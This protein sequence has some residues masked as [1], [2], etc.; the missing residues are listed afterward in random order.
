MHNTQVMGDETI[1]NTIKYVTG[2]ATQHPDDV[3]DVQFHGGEPLLIGL[4]KLNYITDALETYQ[5][6]KLSITTNLIYDITDEHIK[7]F[8]R[9]L[10]YDD[11][12]YIM[13]SWDY[14]IRFSSDRQE[15]LWET[16]V[17]K[18]V[19][20]GIKLQ[21]IVCITNE[22]IKN[23]KP[24]YIFQKFSR[25]GISDVNFER[26]T[27]TGNVIGTNLMP[28]NNA[29]DG[30]LFDAYINN[31][32]IYH[33]HIPLF[34]SVE[35]SVRGFLNGCRARQ[36]MKTVRT[37]NPDG[38]I[39]AC[40]N[41]ANITFESV[42]DTEIKHNV[43]KIICEKERAVNPK[44]FACKYYRYCNGDCCQLRWDETGCPGLKS[45]YAKVVA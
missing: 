45:I 31:D 13:T 6:I 11:T 4:D 21:P 9:M 27:N 26:L 38:S 44:C 39:S 43:L 36:C 29:V 10:P 19:S 2:F 22:I 16:N 34:E 5:N 28:S 18:L 37:I 3:I 41:I 35:E 33:F 1:E 24:E 8:K 40:P 30:W 23:V 14:M 25:L 17:E 32:E 42:N 7:F 15:K 12:P 20:C